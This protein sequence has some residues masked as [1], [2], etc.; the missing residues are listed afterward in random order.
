MNETYG[1]TYP[2]VF[3]RYIAGLMMP[4]N[5]EDLHAQAEADRQLQERLR[6]NGFDSGNQTKKRAMEYDQPELTT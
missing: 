2:E 4:M 3:S 5:E 1:N 6:H